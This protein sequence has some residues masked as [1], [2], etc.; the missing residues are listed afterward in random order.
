FTDALGNFSVGVPSGTYRV[1]VNPL[2]S[3]KLIPSK[4]DNVVV[5]AG[6]LNM[7]TIPFRPGRWLDVTLLAKDT[8][9]PLAGGNIDVWDVNARSNEIT[10]DDV[11]GPAGTT[12]I[13][14]DT[15]RCTIKVAPPSAQYDTAYVIGLFQTFNDTAI[16]ILMPRKG[17]L[18]VGDLT[19]G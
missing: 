8:N 7:G 13:V 6:N 19:A 4:T 12:R 15:S 5:G 2:V 17:V 1:V 16:T 14:I 18:G 10:I 9:Q 3:T 11:T